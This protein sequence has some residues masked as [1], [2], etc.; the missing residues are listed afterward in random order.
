MASEEGAAQLWDVA[1]GRALWPTPPRHGSA[2]SRVEFS[3]QGRRL[4]TASEDN[5]A[6]VWD[7]ATGRPLT[8]PLRHNGSV[9]RASFCPQGRCVFTASRDGTARLWD[10]AT[11][12]PLTPALNAREVIQAWERETNQEVVPTE[13]GPFTLLLGDPR[14]ADDLVALGRVLTG[15]R[16][17]A[18]GGV[19]PLDADRQRELWQQLRA[20]YPDD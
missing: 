8:P 20:Q 15:H 18:D 9:Y 4:A 10:A 3:P 6:R 14:P 19:V 17:D 5:T 16:I 1:T 13:P 11:G 7:T 12:E 2:I